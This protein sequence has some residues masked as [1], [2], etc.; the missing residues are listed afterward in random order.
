[1]WCMCALSRDLVGSY[2]CN[3]QVAFGADMLFVEPLLAF[4]IVLDTEL[5]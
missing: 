1:M 3:N 2:A 5:K 4:I